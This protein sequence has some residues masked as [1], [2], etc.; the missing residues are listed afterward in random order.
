MPKPVTDPSLL[1]IL[2]QRGDLR[3]VDDPELLK[4]LNSGMGVAE[5]GVDVLKSGG[6]GLAESG[7]SVAGLPGD[8]QALVQKGADYFGDREGLKRNLLAKGEATTRAADLPRMPTSGELKGKIEEFTG[9]FYT[10]KTIEGEYARTGGQF[11]INAAMGPGGALRRAAQV[12]APAAVSE[13]AGQ[14]SKGSSSEPY[15]RAGGAVLGAFTPSILARA[16]SPLPA[17][18][19]RQRMVDTLAQE[20][21]VPTAGQR[22]GSK[23]LQYMESSLGDLPGAGG[24]ATTATTRAGE[25][26][27]RAALRRI[28]SNA[29]RALP[30]VVDEA[31]TRIGGQFDALAGRNTL[32][33]DRQLATDLTNDITD[34]YNLVAPPNQAP[35]I[36]NYLDEIMTQV[37]RNGGQLPG[38]AYQSLRSR[39]ERAARGA[40]AQP[41]VART[42]RDMR[43]SLDDAMERS[44]QLSGNQADLGAWR[45]ARTQYRNLLAIERTAVAG[46]E[47]AAEGLISPAQLRMAAVGQGRRAYARGQGDFAEL[48]RAGNAVMAPLPQSGT[49]PRAAAIGLPAMLGTA[50]GYLLG[51]GEGASMGG[52]LGA[53][54]SA[55]APSTLG[56]VLM[57][58]IVQRYLGNQLIPGRDDRVGA[59]AL[60]QLLLS[61]PRNQLL[62][63]GPR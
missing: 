13:T 18:P 52:A 4:Q 53:A 8:V 34:Y 30:E 21:V 45:E 28:G 5:R 27:T 57:S 41:E 12:F 44:I 2:D 31:F 1:A 16:V 3:P 20:G 47:G 7:I 29:D 43:E 63:E 50:G 24:G 6:V 60:A 55:T 40:Q 9:P 15:M 48:A 32:T 37:Q 42:I 19:V 51:G 25:Q 14:I 11:A 38:E 62:L 17:N 58:P 56:R 23:S 46:G 39:M 49:A 33:A 61:E 35:V 10:P 59:K 54:A 36:R 26:F 22:T